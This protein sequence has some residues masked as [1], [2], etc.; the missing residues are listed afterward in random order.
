V[1]ASSNRRQFR[2]GTSPAGKDV[3]YRILTQ[4]KTKFRTDVFDESTSTKISFGKQYAGYNGRGR[5]R[6]G[7]KI[8]YLLL[9]AR[10]VNVKAN[11][12]V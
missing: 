1:R 6:D 3:S 9:K 2:I 4:G 12:G 8:V 11:H 7:G 5:F 10:R